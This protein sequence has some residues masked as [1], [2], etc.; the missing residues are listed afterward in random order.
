MNSVEFLLVKVAEEGGEVSQAAGK[1]A[2]YTLGSHCPVTGVL[3][4]D[5]LV[6]ECNDVLALI[7]L[8][9]AEFPDQPQL[10]AGVGDPAA[11]QVRK[12][13]ILK[14]MKQCIDIGTLVP[15]PPKGAAE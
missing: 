10:F 11:V 12:T 5:A 14:N 1:A 15:D 3:N 9:K 6:N 2:V 8:L 7:E 4:S 13:K